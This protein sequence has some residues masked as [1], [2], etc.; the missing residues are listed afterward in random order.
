[1]LF[2]VLVVIIFGSMAIASFRAAPWVPTFKRD[3]ARMLDLAEIKPGEKVIDLG[4][5]DGRLV[6]L[7]AEKYRA[8]VIGFEISVL[9]Y[10]ISRFK[11]FFLNRF[12]P[13]RM[14]GRAKIK[15]SDFYTQDFSKADIIV[16]FLTPMAMKKLSPKFKKELK[17]GA[18][19]V[20]YCFRIHDQ[21]P[22][23]VSKPHEKANP[24]FL[25]KY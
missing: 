3:L 25:Y 8:Q 12:F 20:S 22:A 11:L 17:P 2:L 16:C 9:P 5:G 10:Y 21:K 13:S 7:A 6:F 15:F 19:V 1:M 23:Q 18:R 4:S 14:E 24:I